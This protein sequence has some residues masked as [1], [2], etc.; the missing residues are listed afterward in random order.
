MKSDRVKPEEKLLG[1][2][3][4]QTIGFRLDKQHRLLLCEHAGRARMTPHEYARYVLIHALRQPERLS[5]IEEAILQL[6]AQVHQ[7]RS[8]L[9]TVTE[10]LLVTAGELSQPDAKLWITKYLKPE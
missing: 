2:L 7:V 6:S 8:D 1:D 3:G 4:P 10:A 9:V 5:A